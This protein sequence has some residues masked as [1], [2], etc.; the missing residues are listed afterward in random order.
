MSQPSREGA[1]RV[2][3]IRHQDETGI[4]N[5]YKIKS[6][7]NF[8]FGSLKSHPISETALLSNYYKMLIYWQVS[9]QHGLAIQELL[10]WMPGN[11]SVVPYFNNRTSITSTSP[12]YN[13]ATC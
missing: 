10:S 7:Y 6:T 2:K 9:Q 1:I 3:K 13:L 5:H 12:E 4:L 11:N 8:P